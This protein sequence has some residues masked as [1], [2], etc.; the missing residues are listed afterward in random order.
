M[1]CLV[2]F[3]PNCLTHLLGQSDDLWQ[4]IDF[5]LALVAFACLGAVR[6][7]GKD[8]ARYTQVPLLNLKAIKFV[9]S[10]CTYLII[11]VIFFL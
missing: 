6:L 10:K 4:E 11:S 3:K 7:N 1:Q 8:T 9:S 2:R 5:Q